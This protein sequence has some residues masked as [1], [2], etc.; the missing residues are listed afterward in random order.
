METMSAIF[1]FLMVIVCPILIIIGL[2]KPPLVIRWGN[3]KT[4][5]RV[6][7]TY[8]GALIACLILMDSSK[9]TRRFSVHSGVDLSLA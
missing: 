1:G 8:G 7:I 3:T 9:V 6:L 2:I 5:A 4:R